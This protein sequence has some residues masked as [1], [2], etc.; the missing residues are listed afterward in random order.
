MDSLPVLNIYSIREMFIQ[1]R[2]RSFFTSYKIQRKLKSIHNANLLCINTMHCLIGWF[3]EQSVPFNLSKIAVFIL[4]KSKSINILIIQISLNRTRGN[5]WKSLNK[6][7][8]TV[9]W[10]HITSFTKLLQLTNS[11]ILLLHVHLIY[12]T[13]RSF[14]VSRSSYGLRIWSRT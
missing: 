4:H 7:N 3:L 13:Y 5:L 9:K 8:R 1:F 6:I 12:T 14:R 2:N 11:L 10:W